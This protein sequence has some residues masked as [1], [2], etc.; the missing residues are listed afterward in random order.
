MATATVSKH[1]MDFTNGSIIKKL[2][3]FAIPLILTNILQGLFTLTDTIVLGIMVDDKAVGAVGA[4]NTLINLFTTFFIGLS[5]GASVVLSKCLGQG[6]VE[7][8]RKVV[9]SS[10]V[11]GLLGGLILG[12]IG[13][14]GAETF[15]TLMKCD[16]SLLPQA[17]SYIRIY[18]IGFPIILFYNFVSGLMRAVGDTFRPMLYLTIAGFAN[19]GLNVFFIAVCN[20]TVEG[21]A[22]GTVGS[23]LISSILAFIAIKKND[24]YARFE[25]KY[26]SLFKKEV[27]EI[28]AIGVPSGI[29]NSLI[30]V[31]N[32]I[33][34]TNVNSF[35]DKATIAAAIS[36]QYNTFVYVVGNSIALAGMAFVSQNYGAGN[37]TRIKESIIKTA[38]FAGICQFI[39][40]L[41]FYLLT[42]PLTRIMSTDPVVLDYCK[43]IMF[44]VGALYFMCGIMETFAFS[45]RA[46]GK[47]ITAMVI[48]IIF[49]VAFRVV[50]IFFVLPINLVLQ[51]IY[52]SYPISWILSIIVQTI[53]L[54]KILKDVKNKFKN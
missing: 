24:G 4:T 53:F 27:K 23:Q 17:V 54:A 42:E 13:I 31:S 50:W 46:L 44:N 33:I 15:L 34:S 49:M 5:A 9:G 3:I 6:N 40:G 8:A 38:I 52:Y 16:A 21:V 25:F 32:V 28:M 45:M 26:F 1:E 10:V 48:A 2:I 22:I 29:Q 19:V 43:I 18:F 36:S 11:L 39:V 37:Y 47:S 12:A 7:K 41:F 30:S 51:M 14:I 35:G 20:L